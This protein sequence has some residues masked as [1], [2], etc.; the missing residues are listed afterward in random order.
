MK[1]KR[2][3]PPPSELAKKLGLDKKLGRKQAPEPVCSEDPTIELRRLVHIHRTLLRDATAIVNMSSDK[4][5]KKKDAD[6]KEVKEVVPCRL[7]DHNKIDMQETAKALQEEAHRLEKAMLV[8]LK[9][10]PIYQEFLGKVK[11]VGPVT[12]GYLI[13]MVKIDRAVKVSALIRYCG[14]GTGKD[15]KSERRGKDEDRNGAPKFAPDGSLTNGTGTFNDELKIALVMCLKFMRMSCAKERETNRYLK[16]WDDAKHT[17]LSFP[18]ERL[19]RVMYAG[20]A[21]DKG[22]RKATDLFLW[23][24]YVMWRTLEGLVVWPDKYSA[25]RGFVHGGAGCE[26]VPKLLTLDEAKVLAGLK[27]EEASAAAE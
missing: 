15:G 13:A 26:N 6:G 17:A 7:P 3:P 12:A 23:D 27:Q 24:L 10:V 20:E 11:G 4:V 2:V 5:W 16:R 9:Q 21:D 18:N 1:D 8:Q 22:R 19:G 25:M 14:F